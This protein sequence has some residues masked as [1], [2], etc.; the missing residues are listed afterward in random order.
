MSGRCRA[1]CTLAA[2]FRQASIIVGVCHVRAFDG[3][4]HAQG[5]PAHTIIPA[6]LNPGRTKFHASGNPSS[7][8]RLRALNSPATCSASRLRV[9]RAMRSH[10][11]VERSI[12]MSATLPD[13]FKSF[14]TGPSSSPSPRCASS[15][16]LSARAAGNFCEI[17]V[18]GDSS[19]R[20]LGC[21]LRTGELHP[22]PV[23]WARSRQ[24]PPGTRRAPVVLLPSAAAV[25]RRPA[26]A[27]PRSP[28]HTWRLQSPRRTRSTGW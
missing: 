28:L 22:S 10:A 12:E 6:V 20:F 2:V 25:R 14:W 5:D 15:R 26:R 19:M 23:R 11:L 3:L 18:I 27:R 13:P 17:V 4:I 1:R 7:T 24:A 8:S 21:V 9:S 16:P